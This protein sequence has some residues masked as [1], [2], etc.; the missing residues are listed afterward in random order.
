[1]HN[2]EFCFEYL[3]KIYFIRDQIF[4]VQSMLL[5]KLFNN[6]VKTILYSLQAIGDG[7]QGW[8]NALLYIF[9]SPV[10]RQELFCWSF[11]KCIQFIGKKMRA[12]GE[13]MET[14]GETEHRDENIE[15]ET[16]PPSGSGRTRRPF[17]RHGSIRKAHTSSQAG[18][19]D[20]DC[21]HT[22]PAI[23]QPSSAPLLPHKDTLPRRIEEESIE[24]RSRDSLSSAAARRQHMRSNEYVHV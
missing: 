23:D 19:T 9:L 2:D 12:I 16:H 22:A 11:I 6:I 13:K 21:A 5:S 17:G 1:M 15:Q 24:I 7:G 8:G 4:M 3:S 14:A 10:I 20:I 18:S